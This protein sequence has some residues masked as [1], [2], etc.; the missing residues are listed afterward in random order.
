[1]CLAGSR[2][3][4]FLP[5]SR[6]AKDSLFPILQHFWFQPSMRFSLLKTVTFKCLWFAC[7]KPLLGR[8]ASQWSTCF[9]WSP[10]REREAMIA[11][12]L[13][14][15]LGHGQGLAELKES[16]LED[17]L[18]FWKQWSWLA[19]QISWREWLTSNSFWFP[20][21]GVLLPW[22]RILIQVTFPAAGAKHQ[23][24][25]NLKPIIFCLMVLR[26]LSLSWCRRHDR[27]GK[28]QAGHV[29]S[30][31]KKQSVNRKWGWAIKPQGLHPVT[32]FL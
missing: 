18:S 7:L 28:R 19:R 20:D 6:P 8:R 13:G 17:F 29:A 5:L 14:S 26:G 22:S 10:E 27:R 4:W 21:Q 25:S 11:P 31:V 16:A 24:R 30:V 3:R 23:T 32:Y 9:C 1:M 12:W 15:S 2:S